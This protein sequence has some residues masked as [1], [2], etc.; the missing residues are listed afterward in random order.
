MKRNIDHEKFMAIAIGEAKKSLDEGG[1]PIGSVLVKDGK[2]IGRGHNQRV[3]KGSAILH[4]EMACLESAGRL[5]AA[6]YEQCILYSTLSPCWMCTGSI[7]LYKIPLVVIGENETFKGPEEDSE[8][9]GTEIINL[10]LDECKALMREFIR[11][12]PR[13]WNED[14]AV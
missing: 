3:Q 7:L 14:I 1:I 10:D 2:V 4:A 5:T 8:S 9:R 12:N 6:D 13:L 11:A